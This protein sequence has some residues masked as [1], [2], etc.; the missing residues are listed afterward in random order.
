MTSSLLALYLQFN[1]L[2]AAA[3]LVWVFTKTIM[4]ALKIEVSQRRQLAVARFLFTGLLLILFC[5]PVS[6][7]FPDD[8][9]AGIA[10]RVDGYWLTPGMT[11]VAGLE[12]G[13]ERQYLLGGTQVDLSLLV[14]L[15]LVAGFA[16][17]A[18]RLAIAVRYLRKIVAD[19]TEWKNLHG[20]Q[21]VFSQQISAPFST[22]AL[23]SKQI[24]L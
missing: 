1:L 24:V 8:W 20:I 4:S 6:S 10:A 16:W 13:L 15:V 14:S 17:Q 19:A 22:L 21:L 3:W 2:L 5:V 18:Y 12:G 9:R 11:I 23:G 7:L